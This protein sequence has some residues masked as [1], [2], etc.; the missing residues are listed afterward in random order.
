MVTPNLAVSKRDMPSGTC[1]LINLRLSRPQW[2]RMRTD[3]EADQGLCPYPQHH[4]NG[5]SKARHSTGRAATGACAGVA[6]RVGAAAVYLCPEVSSQ[7]AC[8]LD[9]Q[10]ELACTQ[11]G[12]G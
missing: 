5:G 3:I 12:G 10:V 2:Q 6:V 9:R 8:V 1:E 4:Y 11:Q 7:V